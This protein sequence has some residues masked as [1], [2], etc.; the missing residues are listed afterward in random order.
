VSEFPV[1]NPVEP[2]EVS[3]DITSFLREQWS[4]LF[5]RL[6]QESVRQKEMNQIYALEET[7]STLKQLVTYL[8]EERSKGDEAIKDILLSSHPAFNAAK[9]ALKVPYRVSFHTLKE[10]EDWLTARGYFKDDKETVKGF[11]DFDA[12]AKKQGIRFAKSLFDANGKLKI[13]SPESW[14][15]DWVDTYP[16]TPP[17]AK[18][19]DDDEIPF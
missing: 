11:I 19:P 17:P 4:G 1:G 10:L 15:D 13:I 16:I 12:D 14:D 2:F 8:T 3:D 18:D 7:A 5:Q 9:T 6:L